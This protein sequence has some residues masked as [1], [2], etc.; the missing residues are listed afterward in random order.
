[1]LSAS[2]ADNINK[3]LI[4]YEDLLPIF[5][6]FFMSE[7]IIWNNTHLLKNDYLSQNF[8][9]YNSFLFWLWWV[10]PL[11]LTYL[12]IW[13][14]SKWI[15]IPAYKKELETETSK[16]LIR[17]S[18][19]KKIEVAK[20]ELKEKKLERASIEVKQISEERKIKEADPTVLWDKDYFNFKKLG[21]SY[22]F[23]SF[24]NELYSGEKRYVHQ[25]FSKD[26]AYFDVLGLINVTDGEIKSL[27]EK[28]R[29][30]A[31]KNKEN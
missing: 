7:D 20:L 8:F 30:F 14:F 2:T 16:T 9:Q 3:E 19:E 21:Y 22:K 10:L 24:I 31:L 11:M 28:G 23:D 18:E 4:D 17:I 13:K 26:I 25:F 15:I 12:T 1:M 6:I 29:Y 5:T 27:T